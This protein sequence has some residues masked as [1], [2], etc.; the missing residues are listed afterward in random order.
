VAMVSVVMWLF[1]I[2]FGRMLMYN[3]TLLLFLGI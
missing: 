3:D 2:F 1:I